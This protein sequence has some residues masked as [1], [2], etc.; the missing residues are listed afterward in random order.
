MLN[1]VPFP[2]HFVSAD[3]EEFFH[4]AVHATGAAYP[5]AIAALYL[6]SACA[7]TRERVWEVMDPDGYVKD[8]CWDCWQDEDSRR[9][10][11]LAVNLAAGP[12]PSS[13]RRTSTIPPLPRSSGRQRNFGSAIGTLP[14]PF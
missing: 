12:I 5:P 1:F 14:E 4:Q 6:L 11:A 9:C 7:E 3:H 8:D 2:F 10:V 13:P